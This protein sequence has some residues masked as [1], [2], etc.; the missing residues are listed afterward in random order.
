MYIFLFIFWIILNGKVTAEII[1]FGI[2]IPAIILLFMCKFLDYSIKK[3]LLLYR[4][5]PYF[6]TYFIVLLKE[7]FWANVGT[8]RFILDPRISCESQ[9]FHFASPLKTKL[10]QVILA[11]SITLTPGTITVKLDDD[12]TFVIHCL[13]PDLAE[14]IEDSVFVKRLKR[15]EKIMEEAK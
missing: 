1:G 9:V 15:I 8:I 13:D 14:G 7:I 2:V 5:V 6:L 12:G 4:L 3:E 10:C 11:N